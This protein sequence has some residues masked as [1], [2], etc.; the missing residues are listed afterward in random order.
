MQSLID[1]IHDNTPSWPTIATYGPLAIAW[2]ATCLALAGWL[3]QHMNWR[4]GYTRKVFHFLI[5]SSAVAVQLLWN[6]PAMCLFGGMTSLVILFALVR[7]E[8]N[9]LYEAMAREKD[10]PHRTRF[11]VVPYFATLIG[12][13]LS[14]LWFGPQFAVAGLLVTGVADAIAEPIGTRFGKHEYRVLS[15]SKTR[16]KRSLEGSTAVFVAAIACVLLAARLHSDIQLSWSTVAL[17]VGIACICTLVEA[18]SPHG[19]DNLTLQLTPSWLLW[20]WL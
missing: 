9:R 20:S 19:W 17:S 10:A 14:H 13:V 18:V 15:L 16:S 2:A 6:T 1:F 8:G 3:K 7:G 12:G 5:F 4:T 11:I